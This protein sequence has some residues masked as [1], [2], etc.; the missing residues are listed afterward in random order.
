MKIIGQTVYGDD[1]GFFMET[2]RESVFIEQCASRQ[3]VQE[4]HSKSKK[5]ILRGLHYQLK[6]TQGKLVRVVSG[7]VYDVAI[8]MRKSS[9]TFGQWVGVYLLLKINVSCGFQRGSLMDFR[10]SPLMKLSLF[11]SVRTIITLNLK[12]L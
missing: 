5:G 8:D 10:L 2:F 3:F 11:I 6:N 7:E 4:N 1:R 12:F 9:K